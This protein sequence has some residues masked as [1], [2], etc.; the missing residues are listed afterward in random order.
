MSSKRYFIGVDPGWSGAIAMLD[1]CGGVI[2][3]RRGYRTA[4]EF[5]LAM[6]RLGL[7]RKWIQGS[8]QV[9]GA[10]ERVNPNPKFGAK[11]NY[12]YGRAVGVLETWLFGVG[13]RYELVTPAVWQRALLKP[14]DG[15]DTKARARTVA[16]R[17]WPSWAE[18]KHSGAC[19]AAL[20]AEWLRRRELSIP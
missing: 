17:L 1:Q 11:G 7:D 19:D 15:K 5:L 10:V 20:I 8:R 3:L 14:S 16:T 13:L 18:L 4:S 6:D 9:C 12:S 2:A